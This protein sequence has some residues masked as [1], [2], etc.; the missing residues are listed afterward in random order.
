MNPS[1]WLLLT[2]LSLTPLGGG[3]SLTSTDWTHPRSSQSLPRNISLSPPSNFTPPAHLHY[4]PLKVEF[5]AFNLLH[6]GKNESAPQ[7]ADTTPSALSLSFPFSD[8]GLYLLVT[9]AVLSIFYLI[10]NTPG[11]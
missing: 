9:G 5:F 1:S 7:L 2:I 10:W 3:D 11:R 4:H 8:L 6:M